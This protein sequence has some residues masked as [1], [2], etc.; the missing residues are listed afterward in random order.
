LCCCR[1][2]SAIGPI[3]QVIASS[4]DLDKTIHRVTIVSGHEPVAHELQ[5]EWIAEPSGPDVRRDSPL[6][7][8]RVRRRRPPVVAEA[9]DLPER[10]NQVLTRRLLAVAHAD[11][12]FAG[13]GLAWPDLVRWC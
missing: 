7:I 9:Q 1:T 12:D 2:D 10:G 4:L 11:E 13:C 6:A 3:P 5:S 8:E